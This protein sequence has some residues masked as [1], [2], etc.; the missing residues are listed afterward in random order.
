MFKIFVVLQMLSL[1][2]A[3]VRSPV[4]V[5]LFLQNTLKLDGTGEALLA[6]Y[7]THYDALS[8]AQQMKEKKSY[9]EHIYLAL[10]DHRKNRP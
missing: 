6:A 3:Q 10:W 7:D 4:T 5:E 2:L 8:P 9:P 1:T